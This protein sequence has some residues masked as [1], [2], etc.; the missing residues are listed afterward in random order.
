M[1]AIEEK[2]KSILIK[3]TVDTS[4]YIL[5]CEGAEL[6]NAHLTFNQNCTV[7]VINATGE[8]QLMYHEQIGAEGVVISS[9]TTVE[10]A[11][12]NGTKLTG[13]GDKN[14][15]HLMG[16]LEGGGVHQIGTLGTIPS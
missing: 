5:D 1:K 2:V 4:T 9:D 10:L 8:T 13:L 3:Y 12:N 16:N 6:V 14:T 7:T 15:Y 11:T